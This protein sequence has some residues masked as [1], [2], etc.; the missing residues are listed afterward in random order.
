[1]TLDEYI[2]NYPILAQLNQ[3]EQDPIY[4][5]EG[6]V[7][8]HTDMV[9]NRLETLEYFKSLSEETR[10]ELRFTAAFHDVGKIWTTVHEPDGRIRSPNHA[11][12]GANEAYRILWD[13]G[14]D[15]Q[16]RY[17]I[18]GLI[19]NHTKPPW[20]VSSNKTERDAVKMAE[21]CP[22]DLLIALSKADVLGRI[23]GTSDG[24]RLL[25]VEL[26]ELALEEH[27][28]LYTKAKMTPKALLEYVSQ[29]NP[30]RFYEPHEDN[31]E[32]PV[33]VMWGLPGSGK[34]TWI[35]RE[36]NLDLPV[37]SLDAIRIRNN[38]YDRSRQSEVAAIAY[39]EAKEFLRKRQPF[40]WNST[41]LVRDLRSKV[42][43][44]IHDYHGTSH[45]ICIDTPPNLAKNRNNLRD[46]GKVPE[47]NFENMLR[48]LSPVLT[49]E[50]NHVKY[51]GSNAGNFTNGICST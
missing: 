46:D 20:W 11:R 18:Y 36:S 4:H 1:M 34:D 28:V 29:A 41:N 31:N 8:V 27:D 26:C 7:A 48:K 25:N 24:A 16:I 39:E 33:Y 42:L 50:A 12:V 51:I 21:E 14:I 23:D 44:L 19:A 22:L 45:V 10:N 49:Y 37:I 30:N 13:Q 2:V 15:P 32:F 47:K 38:I 9:L 40:I 35:E 3:I 6:N 5:A 17:K 43:K